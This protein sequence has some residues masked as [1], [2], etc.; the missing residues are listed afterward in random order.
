MSLVRHGFASANSQLHERLRCGLRAER[1]GSR[2]FLPSGGTKR[3]G[4]DVPQ[5][6]GILLA[7]SAAYVVVLSACAFE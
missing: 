1:T 6:G 7:L 4:F 3:V 5:Y 2:A